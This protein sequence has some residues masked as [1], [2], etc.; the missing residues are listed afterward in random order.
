M[1]DE[2]TQFASRFT[3]ALRLLAAVATA[4]GLAEARREHGAGLAAALADA[5]D[6]VAALHEADTAAV[7]DWAARRVEV[8]ARVADVRTAL[9][10]GGVE[11]AAP[12][13]G[14]LVEL[15]GG[16][17]AAGPEERRGRRGKRRPR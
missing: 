8:L 12:G 16:A 14:A 10:R 2:T 17:P 3:R 9:A 4:P 1:G 11:Q 5:L 13:A 7:K 15:V 6:A